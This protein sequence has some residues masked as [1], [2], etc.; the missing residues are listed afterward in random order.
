MTARIL[1]TGAPG[2]VGTEVVKALQAAKVPFRIGAYS[3]DSARA[4]FGDDTEIVHFDFLKPETFRTAFEGIQRMFLVRPPALAD[5]QE[6]IAPALWAALGAGVEHIVFL[7]LQGVENNRVTPHYKIEKH[8]QS[9][10]IDYTFLRASFFMQNLSTTHQD[11]I[12][13]DG[14]IRVPVGKAKTSFIDV[15]DIAAVA[16]R[17]LT[18]DGHANQAYTLTGP[19]ALDYHQIAHKLSAVI[20]RPVTYTNPS[21]LG[22]LRGQLAGGKKLGYALVVSALYTITRFGNAKHVTDDVQQVLER[23]ATTFDQFAQDYRACW[24]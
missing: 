17:A 2:N 8:I 22:F 20:G 19:E 24:T 15:R 14:E 21:L 11:E 16:A 10:K 4:A 23:E 13:Q 18:E 1:V 5:V 6:E 7:S 9:M 3:V 12:R